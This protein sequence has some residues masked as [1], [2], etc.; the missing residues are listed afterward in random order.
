MVELK[1]Q[2]A[3]VETE[4]LASDKG[5]KCNGAST[6]NR[7]RGLDQQVSRLNRRNPHFGSTACERCGTEFTRKRKRQRYCSKVCSVSAAVARHRHRIR[8]DGD[9]GEVLTQSAPVPSPIRSAYKP[10]TPAPNLP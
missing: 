7:P 6:S 5:V 10:P 1:V 3:P 9:K 4:A 8:G 2:N